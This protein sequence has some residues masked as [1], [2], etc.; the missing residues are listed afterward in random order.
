MLKG[1]EVVLDAGCG[2]GRVAIQAA[3]HLK[4]GKVIGVDKW[5]RKIILSN[6]P[7]RAY[8]NAEAEG[9]RDRVEFRSG[10][11]FKLEFTDNFFDAVT[12]SMVLTYRDRDKIFKAFS[13]IRRVLKPGG[14]FLMVEPLKKPYM[15]FLL[16]PFMYF[17]LPQK[18][19][20]LGLMDQAGFVSLRYTPWNGFGIFSARGPEKKI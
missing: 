10:D 9:V 7:K 2:L 18:G 20:W 16:S 11:L 4:D 13:E 19:K 15:F 6:S 12:C 3:R 14:R 5:Y 8:S 17:K 1:D